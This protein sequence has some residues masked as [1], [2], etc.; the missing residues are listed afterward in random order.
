[1]LLLQIANDEPPSP[2]RLNSRIPRDLETICLKCMAKE[3]HR[4][5]QTAK[6]VADELQRIY[7]GE[8]HD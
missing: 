7:A 6:D 8:L 4:R 5:Y 1:M 2:R 3:Q